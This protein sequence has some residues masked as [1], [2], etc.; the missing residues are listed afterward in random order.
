M[1][2][3]APQHVHAE[4]ARECRD[5][6]WPVQ[7]LHFQSSWV[8]RFGRCSRIR[9][10]NSDRRTDKAQWK[11]LLV[12]SGSS[13]SRSFSE[14]SETARFN[15]RTGVCKG[16][17]RILPLR[18]RRKNGIRWKRKRRYRENSWTRAIVAEGMGKITRQ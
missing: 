15:I 6:R 1:D 3:S 18:R 7:L 13:Y 4:F 17:A 10:P 5:Q 14:R 12:H 16:R 11:G 9:S 2:E 8:Y